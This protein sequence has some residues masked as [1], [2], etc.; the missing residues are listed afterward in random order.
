MW[1]ETRPFFFPSSLSCVFL[2]RLLSHIS[3]NQSIN[4]TKERQAFPARCVSLWN[5]FTFFGSG[6]L[7]RGN[8]RAVAATVALA[9]PHYLW[10]TCLLFFSHYCSSSQTKFNYSCSLAVPEAYDSSIDSKCWR[11][12]RGFGLSA[13]EEGEEEEF[14]RLWCTSAANSLRFEQTGLK[15]KISSEKNQFVWDKRPFVHPAVKSTE[16]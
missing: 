8:N 11:I 12:D 14:L 4:C 6:L 2:C 10:A 1:P 16:A 7:A 9:R 15:G 13:G 5:N 3:S